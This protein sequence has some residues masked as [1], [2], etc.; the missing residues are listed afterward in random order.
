[1]DLQPSVDQ[2]D[3]VATVEAWLTKELSRSHLHER[4]RTGAALD[5]AAWAKGADLGLFSLGLPEDAGGAGCPVVEEALVARSLGRHLAPVSFLGSLLGARLA[6]SAG[7]PEL[8]DA[9]AGGRTRVAVAL[10]VR[11][12]AGTVDVVDLPGADQVLVS[13][14]GTL[15]LRRVDPAGAEDR[16]CLDPSSALHRLPIAHLSEPV[17]AADAASLAL[18]GRLLT[19][20]MLVG[21]AEAARDAAVAHATTREQFGR[22]IGVHQA[23]KHPV[24]EMA[25]RCEAASSLLLLAALALRDG[26][27]DAVFQVAAAKRMAAVAAVEN[28]RA[29]V[30]VHGG[31]GFTWE[32]DAH[33]F[34]T[35]A[36]LLDELF[37]GRHA[38]RADVL[39][40]A[41]AMP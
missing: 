14:G 36:H 5:A 1:V 8:R 30:Q 19:A 22:P 25:V 4:L 6:H 23:V 11:P 41:P 12:G 26:R 9:L 32:N 16:D 38:V 21:Q 15:A 17:T 35:R 40:H 10:P 31:M 28:A 13:D 2:L 34:L 39:A 7:D 24:A 3:L 20:A 18:L 37:G 29:D 33:L 27:S